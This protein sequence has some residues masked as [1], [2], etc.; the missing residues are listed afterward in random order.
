MTRGK[1]RRRATTR[2]V[3]GRGGKA[4][5]RAGGGALADRPYRGTIAVAA[6]VAWKR[7]GGWWALEARRP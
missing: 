3:G 7:S 1:R 5:A 2:A 6:A 4:E